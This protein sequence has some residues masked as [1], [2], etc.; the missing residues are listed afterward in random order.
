MAEKA[1]IIDDLIQSKE[2]E[3]NQRLE[4]LPVPLEATAIEN[5]RWDNTAGAV[6]DANTKSDFYIDDNGV[7]HLQDYGPGWQQLTGI[8]FSDPLI[9]D[10]GTWRV[11]TAT[12]IIDE[13]RAA[14][15]IEMHDRYTALMLEGSG[16]PARYRQT[17]EMEYTFNLMVSL[18]WYTSD[19]LRTAIFQ[20]GQDIYTEVETMAN[21]LLTYPAGR[22]P[23]FEQLL[24]EGTIQAWFADVKNEEKIR[25][26][27]VMAADYW[28]T[29]AYA[30]DDW[31]YRANDGFY[32]CTTAHTAAAWASE[33]GNWEKLDVNALTVNP[34]PTSQLNS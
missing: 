2:T 1:Y 26:N 8:N 27:G 10:A 20:D 18:G 22:R 5:L 29:Q 13:A 23:F 19:I 12:E 11:K 3:N 28:T 9:N 21:K 25:A 6:V 7:K 14:I 30:L 4:D 16:Y 17:P 34:Y 15:I 32:K 31:V 24:E 33:T